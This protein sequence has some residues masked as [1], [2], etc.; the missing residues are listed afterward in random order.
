MSISAPQMSLCSAAIM[1][2]RP[3]KGAWARAVAVSPFITLEVM[4]KTLTAKVNEAACLTMSN[5]SEQNLLPASGTSWDE[6]TVSGKYNSIVVCLSPLDGDAAS[7]RRSWTDVYDV[8][9]V[10][11]FFSVA[12][13]R[14]IA[15]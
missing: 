11:R 12:Q 7:S 3:Y 2:P 15:S 13:L 8:N 9:D 14:S 1:R 4:T 10:A 6:A 5:S